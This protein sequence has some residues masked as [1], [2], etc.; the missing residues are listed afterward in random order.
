V[1]IFDEV[2]EVQYHSI[3]RLQSKEI[4]KYRIHRDLPS[5]GKIDLIQNALRR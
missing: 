3:D 5:S 1:F 4:D 2:V